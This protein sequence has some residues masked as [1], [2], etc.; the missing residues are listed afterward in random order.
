MENSACWE[1]QTWGYDGQGIFA[2]LCTLLYEPTW[3]QALLKAIYGWRW[4]WKRHSH[5]LLF[6]GD[7]GWIWCPSYMA[8]WTDLQAYPY[9]PRKS[10]WHHS[11]LQTWSKLILLQDASQRHECGLGVSFVRSSLGPKWIFLCEEWCYVPHVQDWHNWHQR[12]MNFADFVL[13]RFILNFWTDIFY[14]LYILL[15]AV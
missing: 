3:L 4:N 1:T 10:R 13:V 5:F 11:V 15:H 8:L 9:W 7:A 12:G 14:S 6:G 2:V